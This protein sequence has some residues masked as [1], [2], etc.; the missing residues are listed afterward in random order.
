MAGAY[1]RPLP[2]PG[3]V[4]TSFLH[5][6]FHLGNVLWVE[7]EISGVVD[8]PETSWGPAW[9]DVAHCTTYLAMLHG[10]E[11]AT[12][13]TDAYRKLDPAAATTTDPR[14]WEVLDIV[15]YLPDPTKVAQPWRDAGCDVSD[16]QARARLE[17][18]LAEVLDTRPPGTSPRLTR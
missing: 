10:A 12:R 17:D 11:A 14:Y 13:F 9:L 16:G 2:P 1:R 6:D 5:R 7:G 3:Y 8:W 4:A 18:R 15:G